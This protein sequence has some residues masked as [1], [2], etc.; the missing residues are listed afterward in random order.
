MIVWFKKEKRNQKSF[1]EIGCEV[2]ERNKVGSIWE[3]I[4]EGLVFY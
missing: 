4:V 3:Q 1:R 2:E